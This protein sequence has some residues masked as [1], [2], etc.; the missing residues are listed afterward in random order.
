M[1]Y[2]N[3]PFNFPIGNSK[4][5]VISL[6]IGHIQMCQKVHTNILVLLKAGNQTHTVQGMNE[7]TM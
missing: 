5:I 1:S 4:S 3:W 6:L 2:L 7:V